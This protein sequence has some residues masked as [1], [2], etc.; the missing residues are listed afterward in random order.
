MIYYSNEARQTASENISRLFAKLAETKPSE[1]LSQDEI[2][3]IMYYL[4][5]LND[6]IRHEM[7]AEKLKQQKARK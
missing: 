2:E 4:K 3:D 7:I 5:T 1:V 6:E